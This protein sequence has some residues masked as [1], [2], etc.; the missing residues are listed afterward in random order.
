[1]GALTEVLVDA[2]KTA[3]VF[4]E[5]EIQIKESSFLPG[6][7][8]DEAADLENAQSVLNAID[9]ALYEAAGALEI[10]LNQL[11]RARGWREAARKKSLYDIPPSCVCM[12]DGLFGMKCDAPK[13]ATLKTPNP[14]NAEP[15]SSSA[16]PEAKE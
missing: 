9:G 10:R 14:A 6:P 11:I 2:L 3:R 12:G 1:M 5:E 8:D 7:T 4:V 16:T 13:H 15:K